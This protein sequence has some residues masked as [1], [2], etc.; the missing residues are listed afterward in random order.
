MSE[1]G[2]PVGAALDR[3]LVAAKEVRG[4]LAAAG[5]VAAD[6]ATAERCVEALLS[7]AE[8]SLPD[9]A[10]MP[11]MLL[12]AEYPD[13]A[14]ARA[15]AEGWLA[16]GASPQQIV[17]AFLAGFVNAVAQREGWKQRLSPA[18]LAGS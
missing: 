5:R 3:L 2:L 17:D 1:K 14:P 18:D 11:L 15:A 6:A 12:S 16:A 13:E 4:R 9:T 8:A 10:M 7:E